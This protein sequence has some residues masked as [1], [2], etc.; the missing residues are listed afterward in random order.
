MPPIIW[1]II[2]LSVRQTWQSETEEEV[3]MS[4]VDGVAIEPI[5]PSRVLPEE[6]SEDEIDMLS[7]DLAEVLAEKPLAREESKSAG[8]AVSAS[9]KAEEDGGEFELQA[10]V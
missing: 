4:N 10:W 6:G 9:V 7:V 1:V 8:S 2:S 5:T 3:D